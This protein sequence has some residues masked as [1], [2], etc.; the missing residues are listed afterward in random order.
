MKSRAELVTASAFG[1][2]AVAAIGFVVA[3]LAN[4][5]TQ[6]MGIAFGVALLAL[7]AGLIVAGRLVVR[8]TTETEPRPQLEDEAA[9]EEVNEMV[10]ESQSD[11]TRRGLLTGAG[12][13]AAGALTVAGIVPLASLGPETETRLGESPWRAGTRLVD[14]RGRPIPAS[15]IVVG[16][17]V[18]GV[19]RGSRS[20]RGWITGDRGGAQDVRAR[21][22]GQPHRLGG[23]RSRSVLEDLH[24]RGLRGRAAP[25]S[26]LPGP[27]A[28]G[29]ALVCPCHYSTFDVR[30]RRHRGVRP[31]RAAAA[32]AA[33]AHRRA[34]GSSGRRAHV[35]AGRPRPGGA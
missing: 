11:V 2:S 29:P 30:Q 6:L 24:S 32:P 14:D 33:A 23:R 28:A 4:S 13:A 10:H 15:S 5:S 18:T 3:Y 20:P 12:I 34:D 7:A 1:I 19:P 17:F 9:V 25:L 21:S 8:Q 22:P 26:A 35:G 31:G 16:S 27:L